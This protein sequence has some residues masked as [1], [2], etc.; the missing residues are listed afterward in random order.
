M[1]QGGL[2]EQRLG[3]FLEVDKSMIQGG[4]A[5]SAGYLCVITLAV[6]LSVAF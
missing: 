2:Q 6:R 3:A 4:H 5:H 1:L